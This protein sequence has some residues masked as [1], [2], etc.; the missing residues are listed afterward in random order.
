[1]VS[2]VK[3]QAP[4]EEHGTRLKTK[5]HT[6]DTA[7][8]TDRAPPQEQDRQLEPERLRNTLRVTCGRTSRGKTHASQEEAQKPT[9]TRGSTIAYHAKQ[10]ERKKTQLRRI[11]KDLHTH[12]GAIS[13]EVHS[14]K[15]K[16]QPP[17]ATA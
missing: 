4:E 15:P 17:Q 11:R 16:G 14:A 8:P 6:K 13:E 2:C 3:P 12:A 9:P 7:N 5:R 1:M 10:E